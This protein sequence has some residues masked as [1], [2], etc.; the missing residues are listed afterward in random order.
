MPMPSSIWSASCMKR[1]GSAST[2]CRRK[3]PRQ[4]ARAAASAGASLVHV[5]A[6]G[7]D[8]NSPSH[9]ARSKAAGERRVLAAE[10]SAVIMRPSFAF[11]PEDEFFNRFAAMAS[12]SPIL[13][14][15]GGGL[16]RSQPVFAGD[17]AASHR[18]GRGRRRQAGHDLRAR[19]TGG[20]HL[21]GIDGIHACHHRAPPL[22]GAGAV[23]AD[24][25]ASDFPAIPA[26]SA[27][28]ARPGGN[29]QGRQRRLPRPRTSR[30]APSRA[31]ASFPIRWRRWCRTI[32]GDSARPASSTA[33][34]LRAG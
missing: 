2:P 24:E 11:G 7:A 27:A 28:H 3:A 26:Q 30:A 17:V 14:L 25:A 1:A 15:P 23:S 19:R 8:E 31:S 10:P 20:P 12:I 29:A 13:P 9:Y 4:V 6:I 16:M 21:Q 33:A 18:Q 22:A 5:S 32:S 34:W